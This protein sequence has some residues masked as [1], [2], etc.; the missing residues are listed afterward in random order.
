MLYWAFSF[1][2]VAA[3]AALFGFGGLMSGSSDTAQLLFYIFAPLGL[4]SLVAWMVK[5]AIHKRR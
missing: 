5:N 2:A 4:A 1:L 3:V